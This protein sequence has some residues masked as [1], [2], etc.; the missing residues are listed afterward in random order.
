M[1]QLHFLKYS[2]HPNIFELKAVDL[3]VTC[4]LY[5][6]KVFAERPNR[7]NLVVK[8]KQAGGSSVTLDS[9]TA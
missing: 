3:N 6:I 4:D 5:C 2:A 1:F 7:A 9:H 8:K